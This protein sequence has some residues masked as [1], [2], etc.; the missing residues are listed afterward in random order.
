MG[1]IFSI[2]ARTAP[3]KIPARVRLPTN[4]V[5]ATV[6]FALNIFAFIFIGLQIRPIVAQLPPAVLREYLLVAAAVLVTVIVVRI[7]WHMTFNA[8]IRWR[9]RC[10]NF[11]GPT[12]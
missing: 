8:G 11:S 5:W 7:A 3:A 9:S 4:A 2:L 6:I 1:W 10:P 12:P